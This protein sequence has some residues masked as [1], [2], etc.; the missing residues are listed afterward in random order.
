MDN[1]DNWLKTS[2]VI[3]I[4]QRL[5]NGEVIRKSIEV[6]RF[7]VNE[8]SIQRDI[9]DIRN[10]LA[11]GKK[12]GSCCNLIYSRSQKGYILTDKDVDWLEKADVLAVAKVLLESRA[13]C[14]EEMDLLINKL[15]LQVT[16]REQQHIQDIICNENFHYTPVK[17]S[18][19]LIDNL[20]T[21][22]KAMKQRYLVKIHYKKE[23]EDQ[24]ILRVVE[25]Q[26]IIFSE[27]YF[28]LIACIKDKH[29][30]FPAVYRMDRIQNL[31]M[32]NEH[33]HISYCNR[34]E[35][36]EFRKRVQFMQSGPLIRIK[37]RYSGKS[38]EAVMD[39]LPT[40]RIVEQEENGTLVETEVFGS[41]IK[42]W[43]LSQ[44][45]YIEVL[46]PLKFREEMKRTINVMSKRY[47]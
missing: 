31:T 19:F 33:Y 44:A 42:M 34:F 46:E 40:A 39:R 10:F 16:P 27:Y 8:K 21:L 17:H 47:N 7:S 29:Y 13:F 32:L 43:L 18:K 6:E 37:F 5:T 35:E 22:S 41:G 20:W 36:G 38:L 9:E 26:G 12:D 3:S 24:P 23:N 28:Y 15:L 14:K 45:E 2:R 1:R 30:D 25:P 11:E 4:F